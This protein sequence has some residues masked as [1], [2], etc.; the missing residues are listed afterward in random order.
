MKIAVFG[1]GLVGSLYATLMAKL[2]HDVTI[3]EKRSDIREGFKGRAR[4]I[5]L[6]LSVRGWKALELA[7]LKPEV[8]K[9]VIPMEGR[10][11]H[12]VGKET[13]LQPYSQY[14]K[15][16]FS[17]S[18]NDLNE[19]LI[20]AAE[21]SGCRFKFDTK[22]LPCENED[23]SIKIE[24]ESGTI[25]TP[26]ADLYI[27]ADGANSITRSY[28]KGC[29]YKVEKISHN[30]KEIEIS[31]DKDGNHK[32]Y[33]QALHIWPR[34]TYMFIGLPNIDG[35]YT[36][37]LF[38]PE[39][40]KN[41]FDEL[42]S[43]QKVKTFFDE[44][45]PDTGEHIPDLV[46]Q[47]TQ[48]P[49]SNLAT[50][51]VDDWYDEEK[52][53]GL[54]GDAAHG[55]IPFYGQGMNSGFED[56][57]ILFELL[58]KEDFDHH[59]IPYAASRKKDTDGIAHLSRDNFIEMRDLVAQPKFQLQKKIE[60]KIQAAYPG[61]WMPLYTMVSFSNIPYSEVYERGQKQQGIMNEVLEINN[62]EEKS[63][64]D[65]LHND[66]LAILASHNIL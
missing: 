22:V 10:M 6:A 20:N 13:S 51:W 30:Y 39:K 9:I 57:S 41:S 49:T 45:F 11:I 26:K 25:S 1:A 47:F 29:K 43:E 58:Q 66:I 4:S 36:G 35:S 55:I 34:G 61:T 64:D 5:N 19:L 42:N 18:R 3:Y 8:E 12:E 7:G 32:L 27:G 28:I 59:F 23:D 56:C 46:E 44:T 15:T 65:E 31:A 17:V 53:I 50:M 40:G 14:G 21:E 48:N 2:G 52:K 63:I 60:R 24:S 38:M 16:I 54:I 62:I 33:K 37:T